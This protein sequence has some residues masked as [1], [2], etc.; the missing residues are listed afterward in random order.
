MQ[1]EWEAATVPL[2]G[3]KTIR[4]GGKGGRF[5]LRPDEQQQF[6]PPPPPH[7]PHPTP[8]TPTVTTKPTVINLTRWLEVADENVTAEAKIR[9]R[10]L[11]SSGAQINQ[12]IV[13]MNCGG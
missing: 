9:I 10:Y 12:L 2:I 6:L 1:A 13:W 5:C 11:S 4:K 3:M 8:P 7:S